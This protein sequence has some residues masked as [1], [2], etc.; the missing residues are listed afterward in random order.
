M[1]GRASDTESVRQISKIRS[2]QDNIITKARLNLNDLLQKRQEEKKLDKK[3]NLL[4][5][6]GATVV[7][8]IVIVIFSL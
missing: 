7:A 2:I 4:I 5:C 1:R 8:T 3:T 6:S